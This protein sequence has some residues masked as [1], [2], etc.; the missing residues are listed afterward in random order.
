MNDWVKKD[1]YDTCILAKEEDLNTS[2]V[3]IQLFRFR[4]GKFEHHHK[5][6]TEFFY[7]TAGIGR[8]VLNGKEQQLMPGSTLLVAPGVRHTFINDS[9]EQLMEGSMVKTNNDP[10]DTYQN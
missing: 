4:K 2:G 9:D 5:I 6:K 8:V 10:T 1:G 3:E 7:F